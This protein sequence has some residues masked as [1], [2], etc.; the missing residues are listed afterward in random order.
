MNWGLLA[1]FA[2]IIVTVVG[3]GFA[4]VLRQAVAEARLTSQLEALKEVVKT[5]LADIKAEHIRSATSQGDRI[6]VVETQ[7]DGVM[8][9]QAKMEGAAERERDLSGVVRR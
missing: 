7:V 8:K 9:W 3:G 5:A 6:G 1:A 4:V 2:G